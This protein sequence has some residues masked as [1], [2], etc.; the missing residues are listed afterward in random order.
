M[1]SVV[2]GRATGFRSRPQR[3][4]ATLL[5]GAASAARG[6]LSSSGRRQRRSSGLTLPAA[7][8]RRAASRSPSDVFQDAALEW[9]V[10]KALRA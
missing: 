8:A 7:A 10:M 3:S 1:F 5:S 4:V 6:E 9:D 2:R